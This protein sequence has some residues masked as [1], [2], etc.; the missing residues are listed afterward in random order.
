[1]NELGGRFPPHSEWA[2]VHEPPIF[3]RSFQRPMDAVPPVMT[4][5]TS[6]KYRVPTKR[7][8]WTAPLQIC[9]L[10]TKLWGTSHWAPFMALI[11]MRKERPNAQC[12]SNSEQSR[13]DRNPLSGTLILSVVPPRYS[14]PS[15]SR[16]ACHGSFHLD[17]RAHPRMNAAL[18]KMFTFGQPR[19]LDLTALKDSGLGHGNVRKAAGTF[20]NGVLSWRIEHR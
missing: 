5:R 13:M 20:G 3:G 16:L 8:C 12:A 2:R 15:S 1:M 17:L 10:A 6:S 14:G 9:L 11:A 19:D 7:C 4:C 18:K